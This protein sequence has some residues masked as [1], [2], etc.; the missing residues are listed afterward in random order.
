ML[1]TEAVTI[2]CHFMF[3]FCLFF[4]R[5]FEHG[6]KNAKPNVLAFFFVIGIVNA[7]ICLSF[8]L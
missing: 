2:W 4:F 5:I 1:R 7:E 6:T 3:F 8:S